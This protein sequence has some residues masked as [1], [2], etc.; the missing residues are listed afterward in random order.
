[1]THTTNTET[2]DL[3]DTYQP[4]QE[5]VKLLKNTDVV[6]L[7]GITGAGKNT[8][9]DRLLETGHFYD[10]VTSV[11]RKPRMNNGVL[12]QHGVDYYF[13][14][15]DEAMK[16]VDAGEYVEVS[17][18]HKRIYGV[19][20]DE[21]RKAHDTKKTA[22]ADVTVL[23]V[24]KYKKISDSVIA[25]FVLPPSFKEWQRRVRLRF[26]SEKAFLEDWPNRRESAIMELQK[27]LSAPYYH[28]VINENI[29]DAVAACRKIIASG[30][31]FHRKDEEMRQLAQQLL[32]DI[33][34]HT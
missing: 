12:E 19:T 15:H 34:S 17:T 30:N 2:A 21:V 31:V 5:G 18:V 14:S 26:D 11:T 6:L 27:A 8:I 16:K 29:N 22:I 25:I 1:M 4:N 24:D 13:L 7:V 3:F 28:F 23:G 33:I 32:D 10:M 20:V 9:L